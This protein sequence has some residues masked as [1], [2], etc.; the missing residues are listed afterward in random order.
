MKRCT[1]IN[2][3]PVLSFLKIYLIYIRIYIKLGPNIEKYPPLQFVCTKI[4]SY[5]IPQIVLW[6][7][8]RTKEWIVLGASA[9]QFCVLIFWVPNTTILLVYIRS[10]WC[11]TSSKIFTLL[12]QTFCNITMIFKVKPQYFQ[13]FPYIQGKD[14]N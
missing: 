1:I 8:I 13:Y 4:H 14:K 12:S 6:T 7:K 9:L 3:K 11:I 2:S 5:D 10:W